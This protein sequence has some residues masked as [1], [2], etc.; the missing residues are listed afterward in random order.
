MTNFS[1][2]FIMMAQ[3]RHGF[4]G[5]NLDFECGGING[6]EHPSKPT[7]YDLTLK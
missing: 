3:R 2:A 6:D 5:Y 4:T 7:Q 1:I